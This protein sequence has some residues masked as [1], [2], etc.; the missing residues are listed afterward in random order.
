MSQRNKTRTQ[1]PEPEPRDEIVVA[2]E[3]IVM[4]RNHRELAQA[5]FAKKDP[6]KVGREL[7]ED[8]SEKGASVRMRVFETLVDWLYG[9]QRAAAA[10]QG[11]RIIWDLPRPVRDPERSAQ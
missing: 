7:L 5:I 1:Q 3:P 2:E 10:D 8:T 6:V 4:P 11:V 9:P